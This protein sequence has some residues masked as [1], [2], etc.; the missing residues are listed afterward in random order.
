VPSF[1]TSKLNVGLLLGYRIEE[2]EGNHNVLAF[3]KLFPYKVNQKECVEWVKLG[4]VQII[5]NMSLGC[6][7]LASLGN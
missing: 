1:R 6:V 3:L 5:S 4:K 2:H 7:Q